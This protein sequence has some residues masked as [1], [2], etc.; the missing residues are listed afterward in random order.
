[1]N[2][3]AQ[4][5]NRVPASAL[6][7]AIRGIGRIIPRQY[8]C[9]LRL[10][11]W[12]ACVCREVTERRLFAIRRMAVCFTWSSRSS[13]AVESWYS[14]G[15]KSISFSRARILRDSTS[16]S[17]ISHGSVCPFAWEASLGLDS[18][19]SVDCGDCDQPADTRDS[20]DSPDTA[21]FADFSDFTDLPDSTDFA[22]SA[23]AIQSSVSCADSSSFLRISSL[24]FAGHAKLV[25]SWISSTGVV[26]AC[27]TTASSKSRAPSPTKKPSGSGWPT[28]ASVC[29]CPSFGSA[30]WSAS[31][32]RRSAHEG[33]AAGCS[34]SVFA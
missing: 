11:V 13:G 1:M 30:S 18:G 34:P 4:A 32:S 25:F 21:D 15:C 33:N 8:C 12:P 9:N 7:D 23:D 29:G 3:S 31:S 26:H 17:L 28:D 6:G 19:D 24:K 10:S 22:D 20:P 2:C 14:C 16:V 27:P 5:W